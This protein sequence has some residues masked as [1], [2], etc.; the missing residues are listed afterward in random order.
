MDLSN[1][2]GRAKKKKQRG[3]ITYEPEFKQKGKEIKVK[4]RYYP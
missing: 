3:N 4:R 2:K 1:R